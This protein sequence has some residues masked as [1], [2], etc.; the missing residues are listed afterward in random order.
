MINFFIIPQN[1]YT[2]V[3]NAFHADTQAKAGKYQDSFNHL[4]F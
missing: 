1:K 4:F 2:P 3:C